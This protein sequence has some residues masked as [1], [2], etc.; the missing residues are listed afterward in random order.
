MEFDSRVRRYKN[1]SLITLISLYLLVLI[2]GIVRSTGSGM[3]CPDW[4]KC[5]G[6]YIPPTKAEQLPSNYKEIYALKR[7]EK[8]IKIIKMLSYFH[9]NDLASKLDSSDLKS[10]HSDDFNATKTWI[11]Y[12]N[13]LFGV[14]VGFSILI[15]AFISIYFYKIDL[16]ITLNTFLSLFLVI[17]EGWIG[18]IV[19]STHLLPFTITIHMFLALAI[20]GILIYNIFRA[21][22]FIS[23]IELVKS[24]FLLNF[25]IVLI[26]LSAFQILL[27]S[28]VR[29]QV[30]IIAQRF[31]YENRSLWIDFLGVIFYVHRSISILILILNLV[32]LYKINIALGTQSL[33][34]KISLLFNFLLW[35]EVL[36]G[37]VMA[38]WSIPAFVQPLHL[39]VGALVIGLQFSVLS[40]YLNS[41]NILKI[42]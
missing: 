4:P 7:Q 37:V 31:D 16:V 2:G 34:Y 41:K 23:N 38:Y 10:A 42:V 26:I 8:N 19:V 21:Y 18:S 12:L 9:F 25:I 29:E 1:W 24:K 30:D 3:G 6:Y 11:E 28:R 33:V 27:G 22:R 35:S 17:L 5:Y 40:I 36:L 13:R 15:L 14:L 32:F 39:F 20:I